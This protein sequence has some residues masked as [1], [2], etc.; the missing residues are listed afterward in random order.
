MRAW[1]KAR[2]SSGVRT[3][4]TGSGTETMSVSSPPGGRSLTA[5]P[6]P[7]SG[8]ASEVCGFPLA[9]EKRTVAGAGAWK[10]RARQSE[11]ASIVGRKLPSQT[12]PFACTRRQPGW[13]PLIASSASTIRSL[14]S[15]AV[16]PAL[17]RPD[18]LR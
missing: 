5:M 8:W 10:W 4:K 12:V 1:V 17:T 3:M 18:Y 7:A 11:E 14:R 9:F 13:E 15:V 16:S 2:K 6:R